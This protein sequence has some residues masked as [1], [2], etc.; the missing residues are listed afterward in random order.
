M[1]RISTGSSAIAHQ[2]KQR[3]VALLG[4]QLH[5]LPVGQ[6]ESATQL[7]DRT[8]QSAHVLARGR[9]DGHQGFDRAQEQLG[10]AAAVR[11]AADLSEPAEAGLRGLE[12]L[13][14]VKFSGFG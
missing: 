9:T 14:E 3:R 5:D 11:L 12:S 10:L 7:G 2:L 4:I 8:L 13:P 1:I 6:D